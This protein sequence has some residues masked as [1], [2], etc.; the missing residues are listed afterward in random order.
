MHL[1]LVALGGAGGSLLRW[2]LG[3]A[4]PSGPPG[5]PWT[6]LAINLAG[7]L[8]LG[9]LVGRTTRPGAPAWVRPLLGAGALGGFTTFSTL[10]V[11]AARLAR[12]GAGGLAALDLL[13]SLGLGLAA[14]AAGLALGA[15]RR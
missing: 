12:A 9:L 7:A 1:P 6:T 5:F 10:T 15:R 3:R 4:L 2:E 8:A 14:A 13:V 11:D